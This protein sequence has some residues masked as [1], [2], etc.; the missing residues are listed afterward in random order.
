MSKGSTQDYKWLERHINA[1]AS[2]VANWPAWKSQSSTLCNSEYG[3]EH[4]NQDSGS[5]G[6][7]R[8]GDTQPVR[9]VKRSIE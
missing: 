3:S 1:A 4:G 7:T 6:S 2:E 5:A 8:T 9:R